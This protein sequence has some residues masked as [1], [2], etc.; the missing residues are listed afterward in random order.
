MLFFYII[1]DS[2]EASIYKN[3]D[4]LFHKIISKDSKGTPDLTKAPPLAGV[5]IFRGQ[6]GRILYIGKAKNLKNRLKAYFADNP[7]LDI[8]KA[9][10]VKL[11]RDTQWIVTDSELEALIL[12]SNLIKEH[13]PPFNIV[14]RDDKHYPY[15]RITLKERWPRIEVVRRIQEDGNLYF[16]PYVPSQSMWEALSV[17]RR[18]FMIRKCRHNID[19][20]TRPCIQHQM[21]R[22]PAPCAGLITEEQYLSNV[23]D[24]V[25][26]L[27]GKRTELLERFKEK[28]ELLSENLLF[29]EAALMR[30]KIQRLERALEQQKVL[31]PEL[32][33]LDVLGWDL[34][35]ELKNAVFNVL[36]I[37]KGL[38]IG[39][40]NFFFR[41]LSTSN[42]EEIVES[43]IKGFYGKDALP[44]PVI[45]MQSLFEDIQ[46]YEQWLKLKRQGDV[47]IREAITNKEL[48]IV[49]MAANNALLHRTMETKDLPLPKVVQLKERLNLKAVPRKIGV[50]DISTLSGSESSGGFIY[51]EQGEFKKDLY[52]HLKIKTLKGIDDLAMM[53]E[54]IQRVMAKIEA[55]DRPSLIIID[56][57]RTHLEVAIDTLNRI[58]LNSIDVVSIAKK[59]DRVFLPTGE[60]VDIE[61]RQQSSLLLKSLRNE[62]HRFVITFH[63][64]QRDRRFLSSPLE[65]IPGLGP[66]RRLALLRHFGSIGAIKSSSV[67]EISKL[68]GFSEKMAEKVYSSINKSNNNAPL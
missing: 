7:S 36:F 35:R 59:P 57:G 11:I 48:E 28:M 56:G 16:G 68:K 41:R 50:F 8:R 39:A 2:F 43:F 67:E 45:I 17:I 20:P 33:D 22:C 32:G 12:E 46:I 4:P 51:W 15:L 49:A 3:M 66:K 34:D 18:H 40:K 26:F 23:E 6:R 65:G 44:P 21:H 42:K 37:R 63:R 14:L 13:R 30:D 9:S 38:L 25:L 58:G 5:Y 27:N 55:P 62:A 53:A 61:D 31:S 52:R 19:K 54:T 1:A 64:G 24:V 47:V 60:V 29:E 10:M